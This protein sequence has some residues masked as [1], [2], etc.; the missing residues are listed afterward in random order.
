MA[1]LST[2][3]HRSVEQVVREEIAP[4]LAMDGAGIEIVSVHDGVV[5][6]RLSGACGG[7]PGSVYAVVM[8]IEEEL[9][10]RVPDVECLE[11]VP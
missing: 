10:C 9:R 5:R 8:G 11:A 3:L 7:C 6:V 2:D 1:E 4:L